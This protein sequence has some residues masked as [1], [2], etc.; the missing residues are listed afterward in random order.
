M[1]IVQQEYLPVAIFI[2][3][4]IVIGIALAAASGYNPDAMVPILSR[5]SEAIEKATGR[6][7]EKNYGGAF[8]MRQRMKL[9]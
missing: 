4:C 6:K 1:D 8:S 2:G 5:M 9:T 3:L 7:E